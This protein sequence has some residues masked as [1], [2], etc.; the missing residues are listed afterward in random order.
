MAPSPVPAEHG[1]RDRAGITPG[2]LGFALLALSL[3][4]NLALAGFVLV[5]D[6]SPAAA[7]APEVQV[8]KAAFYTVF[9]D[10]KEAFAGHIQ[11]I[12]DHEVLMTDIYYLTFEADPSIKDPKP[13]DFKPKLKQLSNNTIWGPKDAVRLSRQKVEYYTELRPDS[14]VVKAIMTFEQGKQPAPQ[15]SPTK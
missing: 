4:L 2:I 3:A 5:R 7:G 11:H 12:N 13:D 8:D 10:D 15:P 14:P 1:I 9:L 6:S